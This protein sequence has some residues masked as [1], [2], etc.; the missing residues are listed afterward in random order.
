MKKYKEFRLDEIFEISGTKSL[1]AG[2]LEFKNEGI[3]FVGRT[4]EFNGIQGKI[5]KQDFEPN[6]PNTITATVIGNYKYVKYQEEPYYCSQNINK[7]ALKEEFGHKLCRYEGM[8]FL[9]LIY[10]FVSK[11]NGQQGGYKLSD[12]KEFKISLP[13]VDGTEKIDFDYM[14]ST[15]KKIEKIE[16]S[17]IESYLTEL[18][19]YD[20]ALTM[21]DKTILKKKAAYKSFVMK[22]L[23]EKLKSPYKGKEKGKKQDNVSKIQNEE[24]SVPLI[25]CKDGNNG[26]MYYG[27]R[28][29]F[30]VYENVIS[31]IYNGPPTEGQT[32]FQDEIGVYTDAYLVAVKDGMKIDREIGLYLTTAI[33]K[34]IHNLENKKYSRGNKATWDDKVENDKIKLPIQIDEEGNPVIDKN[35]KYHPKGYVPDWD[36]M[37]SYISAIEKKVVDKVVNYQK[38][39]K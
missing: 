31:I 24:F 20:C 18:G 13:L 11:Y 1:D 4:N 7:L 29:D 38:K 25:N 39:M 12:I 15:V 16:V 28:E 8:Y 3:N 6:E 5:E 22:D 32:Y 19:L 26:V 36:Y 37:H 34:S 27:R 35:K 23:F 30:T 9:P 2:A 21:E 17:K 14:A 33:N 10:K